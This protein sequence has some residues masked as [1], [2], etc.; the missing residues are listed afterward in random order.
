[1][2]KS[3]GTLSS[4]WSES[5]LELTINIPH[6]A[7]RLAMIG[8]SERNLKIIRES[9]G[10]AI[11]ARNGSLRLSGDSDAVGKAAH[12]LELLQ[13]AARR[14]RPMDRQQLLDLI[15]SV[16]LRPVGDTTSQPDVALMDELEVYTPGRRVRAL[17]SSQRAYI[18]AIQQYDLTLCIGPAGTG[19][20]YLAVATAVAMLKRGQIRRLALVR[21]AVEAGERLGFLPGDMQEKV[22]PYLRPLL[23][24][25][26]DMMQFE[27]VQRLMACDV[28]EV[29]PLAYMR[30]RTL[31]DALIILDE[32]QNTTC[33]QMLMFLTRLGH[34]GKMVVTGDTTQIDLEDPRRSGLIDAARRLRRVKGVAFV[35]LDRHDIVRHSLVQRIVQ[36]YGED[37]PHLHD[38]HDEAYDQT[39]PSPTLGQSVDGN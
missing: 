19:K 5:D 13:S 39:N 32:A 9:M 21:P 34:G 29:V 20:T 28:I 23:D 7:E 36:A 26:R 8:S 30:G 17:T 15:A 16:A 12:V 1:M 31:N 11:A 3:T 6:G 27:H 10:V 14:R 38:Q 24:A 4:T 22:N 35:T 25:L 2:I 37:V 18:R 33:A